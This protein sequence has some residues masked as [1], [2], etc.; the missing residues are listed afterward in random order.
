MPLVVMRHGPRPATLHG[1]ARLGAVEGLN[2]A[3]LI[4]AEDDR[5]LRRVQ[6]QPN[7]VLQLGEE[8]GV[9]GHLE[10]FLAMGL[11]S[12]R[13]PDAVHLG[14]AEPD[15]WG[16]RP[17]APVGRAGRLLLSRPSDHL[18]YLLGRDLSWP[19]RSTRLLQHPLQSTS[20]VAPLPEH[21]GG[22]G[23]LQLAC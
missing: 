20:G 18:R 16:Q 8:G 23:R 2:L 9:G 5:L 13:T 10:R 14:M 6:I 15:D 4:D 19:P 7:Y 3:L 22:G 17:R 1:Q 11:Q 21:H 12:M